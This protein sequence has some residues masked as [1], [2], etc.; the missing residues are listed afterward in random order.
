MKPANELYIERLPCESIGAYLKRYKDKTGESP[1]MSTFMRGYA[2][3]HVQYTGRNW[4]E[5]H[6]ILAEQLGVEHYV[7]YGHDFFF[8][9]EDAVFLFKLCCRD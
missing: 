2:P 4:S 6:R 5:H 3:I 7:W 8:E 9:N 1:N